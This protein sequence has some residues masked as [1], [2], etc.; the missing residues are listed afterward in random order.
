MLQVKFFDTI[1]V[2]FCHDDHPPNESIE[3]WIILKIVST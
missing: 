1:V 3:L 2:G